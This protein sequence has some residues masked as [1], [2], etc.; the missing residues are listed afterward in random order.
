MHNLTRE[1]YDTLEAYDGI[2]AVEIAVEKARLNII[3]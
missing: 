1:G 2:S 3:R